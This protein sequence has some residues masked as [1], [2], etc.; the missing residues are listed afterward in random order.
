MLRQPG[1]PWTGALGVLRVVFGH[2]HGSSQRGP[3]LRKALARGRQQSQVYCL[4]GPVQGHADDVVVFLVLGAAPAF[5]GDEAVLREDEVRV[6]GRALD[7]MAPH[8]LAVGAVRALELAHGHGALAVDQDVAALHEREHGVGVLGHVVHVLQ[9][10]LRQHRPD[11]GISH[12]LHEQQVAAV[13]LRQ[14]R[15]VRGQHALRQGRVHD[16]DLVQHHDHGQ[17]PLHAPAAKK[18]R[19]KTANQKRPLVLEPGVCVAAAAAGDVKLDAF[20]DLVLDGDLR[21]L[22]RDLHAFVFYSTTQTHT[23]NH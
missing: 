22:A 16:Q 10:L 9:E 6:L 21:V 17:A 15:R 19:N 7:L 4:G 8:G 20:C 12:L 5:G 13:D 3:V 18:T 14:D 1:V 2:G 23:G 11:V